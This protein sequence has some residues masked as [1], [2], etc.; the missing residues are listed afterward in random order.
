METHKNRRYFCLLI[1]AL[2]VPS[3]LSAQNPE[4]S[5]FFL[6]KTEDGYTI[7]QIISFPAVPGVSWYEVEI[8]ELSQTVPVPA[9]LLIETK[10]NKVEVSLRAGNYRYRITAYNKMNL[11][12]GR[13]GWQ[14]FRVLPAVQP[15]LVNYQPFYGLFFEVADPSGSLLVTG[16][17]LSAESEFALVKHQKNYN[18][19][20]VILEERN[21]V[22]LPDHVTIRGNQAQL[23][24]NRSSLKKGTYDIFVRNPGGLWTTL[25]QVRAGFKE[26]TDFTVS[27]GYSPM[28]AAFDIEKAR[29]SGDSAQRLD[30]LNLQ[31]YYFRFGGL[32]L[33]TR[34]GNFGL[35]MQLYFLVDKLL[36]KEWD[37][38]SFFQA[39]NYGTVNLLYQLPLGERWQH[40]ARFGAG[41]GESFH[42]E[43]GKAYSE[44]IPIYF[45]LGYSAQFFLWK[46]FYLEAGLDIQYVISSDG[47]LP[48]NHLMFRPGI[49]LGWQMG[50][51]AEYAE[52]MEGAKQGKDYSVPVTDIPGPEHLFSVGWSPMVPLFGIDLYAA[53]NTGTATERGTQYLQ[54]FNAGGI[55]FRYAYFPYLWGGSKLGV[56]VELHL[57]HHNG[58]DTY[59]A[60]D[61]LDGTLMLFNEFFVGL[62]YQRVLNESWQLNTRAAA[63]ISQGYHISEQF[64]DDGKIT[65]YSNSLGLAINIGGSAQY[66]F[67]KNA[68]VE[69]GLDIAFIFSDKTKSVLRP[70]ISIGWQF[71][72]NTEIGLRLPGT[73]LPHFGSSAD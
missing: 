47:G 2:I 71:N 51:W 3:F 45:N 38:Y 14:N 11:L 36:Q 70:G 68:Y 53:R 66:F 57:L 69:A 40:N 32:P 6:K 56:D 37:D 20:G 13:S 72:R 29:S 63:G 73:G 49:G 52:V 4:E 8:E 39:L 44:I 48:L 59:S 17:D 64:N 22:I 60:V 65:D 50:R 10:T 26:N 42:D 55:S 43:T 31:G 16:T 7:V 9:A 15:G 25:G 1:L 12:E 27:F 28:I 19:T 62:R 46:N 61:S 18:W 23:S 67:W 35:E 5:H 54:S 58:R 34:M 24:F 21:D 41:T 33:K 30:R